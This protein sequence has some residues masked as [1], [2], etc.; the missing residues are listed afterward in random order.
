MAKKKKTEHKKFEENVIITG[1]ALEIPETALDELLKAMAQEN[2][3]V[4]SIL[5]PPRKS[6]KK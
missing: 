3:D 6:A 5:D 4:E 1:V 2:T